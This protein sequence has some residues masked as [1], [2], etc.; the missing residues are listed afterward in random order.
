MTNQRLP[1]QWLRGMALGGLSLISPL[2]TAGDALKYYP[3]SVVPTL[4]APND[5]LATQPRMRPGLLSALQDAHRRSV[6]EGWHGIP[7]RRGWSA[8]RSVEAAR[9][10]EASQRTD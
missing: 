7:D 4:P 3:T 8:H 6:A 2:S 10:S 5:V 9:P 1:G